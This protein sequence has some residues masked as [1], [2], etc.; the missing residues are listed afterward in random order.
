MLRVRTVLAQFNDS[1]WHDRHLKYVSYHVK[2]NT[3]QLFRCGVEVETHRL[4]VWTEEDFKFEDGS[5]DVLADQVGL[6]SVKC[7]LGAS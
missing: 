5:Q 1:Q 7:F 3:E 6:T 2:P 4:F